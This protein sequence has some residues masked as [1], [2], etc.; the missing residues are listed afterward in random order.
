M[1]YPLGI[2]TRALQVCFRLAAQPWAATGHTDVARA[3]LQNGAKPG[4]QD[5]GGE[6]PWD[7]EAMATLLVVNWEQYF[8]Q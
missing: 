6:R 5:E 1:A 3:L 7:W 2:Y 4:M 8:S